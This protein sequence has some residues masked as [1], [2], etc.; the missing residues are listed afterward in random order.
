MEGSYRGGFEVVEAVKPRLSPC[1][2]TLAATRPTGYCEAERNVYL[3]SKNS[4][5]R[6][7]LF[8]VAVNPADCHTTLR[9]VIQY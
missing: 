1:L 3:C 2:T 5:S 4:N 7:N 8:A 6:G 9:I